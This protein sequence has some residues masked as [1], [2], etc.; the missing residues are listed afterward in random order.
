MFT[1]FFDVLML[2]AD[3]LAVGMLIGPAV[4]PGLRTR[5]ALAFGAC[6]G[7]AT[8]VGRYFGF[9]APLMLCFAALTLWCLRACARGALSW[10]PSFIYGLPILFSFDSLLFPVSPAD[11]SLLGVTSAA[12]A[13]I[14]LTANAAFG[15]LG[16]RP[17]HK[18]ALVAVSWLILLR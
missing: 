12:L 7:L 14:G 11:A 16:L 1:H 17:A 10:R 15:W 4:Q 13:F 8:I 2:S 9:E 3:S 18:V 6:D 5:L